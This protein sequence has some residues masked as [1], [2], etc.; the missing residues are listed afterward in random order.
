M[1]EQVR[2]VNREYGFNLSEDEIR[3]IAG[4]A[5]EFEE[6]FRCLYEANLADTT[7]LL[8]LDKTP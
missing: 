2:R 7:P 1:E 6:L 4:R 5:A 3:S 8:K